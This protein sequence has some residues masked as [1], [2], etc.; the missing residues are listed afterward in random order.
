[1]RSTRALF[2]VH[3]DSYFAE[4]FRAACALREIQEIEGVFVFALDIQHQA[5]RDAEACRREGFR[6]VDLDGE[7][8]APA[9]PP[10]RRPDTGSRPA[11][12]DSIRIRRRRVHRGAALAELL[13]DGRDVVTWH[14]VLTR[15]IAR[16]RR[17]LARVEPDVIFL[18]DDNPA[19]DT[20]VWP[21]V[22]RE[23]RIPTVVIPYTLADRSELVN[24]IRNCADPRRYSCGRLFNRLVGRLFPHW[25]Y[26]AGGERLLR[27]PGS[28][29][30]AIELRG[31]SVA[32]PWAFFSGPADA[33]AVESEV[34]RRRLLAEGLPQKK[35]VFTGSA[36]LDLLARHATDPGAKR[37]A[38]LADLGLDPTRPFILWGLTFDHLPRQGCDFS[39]F[40]TLLEFML[41]QLVRQDR[42]QVVIRP[43]PRV[44]DAEVGWIRAEGVR[45]SWRDTAE[46]IPLCAFYVASIS[47]SIRWAIACGR[48]VLNYDVYRYGFTDYAGAGGVVTVQEQQD[49]VDGLDRMATEPAYLAELE[50]SQ[51]DCQRDWGVLDGRSAERLG[52]LVTTLRE[53]YGEARRHTD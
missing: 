40:R 37:R 22:A 14:R 3:F 39:R 28:K 13:R 19:N 6:C 52:A 4:L 34:L 1:M 17:L 43:H 11:G 9:A 8:L 12:L 48:P 21:R 23:E 50:T 44:T 33:I 15:R 32:N 16:T 35:L 41:R 51:R 24:G 25:V 26:D 36:A 46:L 45:V 18:A 2:A 7:D 42:F 10:A 49:F 30:L 31:L 53:Q 20:R 47:A 5:A 38:L 29:I 27:E